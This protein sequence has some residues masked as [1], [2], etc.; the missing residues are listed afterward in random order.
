VNNAIIVGERFD[1]H[2]VFCGK[3]GSREQNPMGEDQ[4]QA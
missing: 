1:L 4:K 2:C 3:N